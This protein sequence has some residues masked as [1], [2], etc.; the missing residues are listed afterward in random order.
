ML[1]LQSASSRPYPVPPPPPVSAYSK[2]NDQE[3]TWIFCAIVLSFFMLASYTHSLYKINQN[4]RQEV[5]S[6][7][8]RMTT[9]PVYRNIHIPVRAILPLN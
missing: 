9:N 5:A 2:L 7:Q 3:W 1:P 8:S 4:L 6:L